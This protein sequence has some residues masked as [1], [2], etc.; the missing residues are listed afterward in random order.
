MGRGEGREEGSR[1]GS[2][3]GE[4]RGTPEESSR[5]SFSSMIDS[6]KRPTIPRF[7]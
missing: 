1:E 7:S 4:R 2:R 6:T 3:G 5:F